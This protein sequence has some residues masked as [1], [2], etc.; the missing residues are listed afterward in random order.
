VAVERNGR[1]GKAIR[2]PG[3]AALNKGRGVTQVLTVSCAPAGIC[4][5]GGYYFDRRDHHTWFTALERNGRW[6]PATQIPGLKTLNTGP[7]S[8]DISSD[9]S[10]SCAPDG[11]CTA[12]AY[13]TGNSGHQG[14]VTQNP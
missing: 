5:A 6:A 8:V 11:T 4:A 3:L 1:W 7:D 13:Y 10:I 12:G 14:F 2:V 9:L